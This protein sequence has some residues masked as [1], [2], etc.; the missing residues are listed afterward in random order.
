MDA[1]ALAR[2]ERLNYIFG[3]ALI[4]LCVTLTDRTFSMGVSLGVVIT[5]ANFAIIRRLVDKLLVSNLEQRNR[6]ALF[7][8][9][10]MVGL[11]VVVTV[12]LFFL[13]ISAIGLAVGFSIFFLTIMVVSIR[14]ISGS[15]LS[16]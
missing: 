7:F 6:T 11:L 12:V 3:A 16:H 13:P 10:K 4:L 15:T 14:Y 9:P 1:K 8:L 2:I 5:C